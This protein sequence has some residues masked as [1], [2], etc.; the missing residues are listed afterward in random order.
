MESDI[1]L[2]E[3]SLKIDVKDE[4]VICYEICKV[5]IQ[6]D[7][8]KWQSCDAC[9][10]KWLKNSKTCPQCRMEYDIDED[11]EEDVTDSHLKNAIKVIVISMYLAVSLYFC[12]FAIVA[13][14]EI[15]DCDYS[16]LMC[17][18]FTYFLDAVIVFILVKS[19]N[20]LYKML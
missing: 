11:E 13:N 14:H 15:T 17:V 1:L 5:K 9:H 12:T 19:Y 4:C 6:C 8:C 20:K 7:N 3:D 16:N 18:V 2:E 10:T